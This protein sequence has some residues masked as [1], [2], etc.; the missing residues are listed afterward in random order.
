MVMVGK[1]IAAVNDIAGEF[2][3]HCGWSDESGYEP[4]FSIH[5]STQAQLL[6]AMIRADRWVAAGCEE[7]DV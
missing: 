5:V 1:R 7:D 6:D 3:V 2:G 4:A